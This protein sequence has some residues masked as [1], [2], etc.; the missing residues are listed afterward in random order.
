MFKIDPKEVDGFTL[1]KRHGA[2]SVLNIESKRKTH[3]TKL[4]E[5]TTKAAATTQEIPENQFS[6]LPNALGQEG[7]PLSPMASPVAT[8]RILRATNDG[9]SSDVDEVS[10][11]MAGILTSD[12]AIN[13]FARFGS[14]TPVKFV[15]LIQDPDAKVSRCP[16][17][18]LL[19]AP[20]I[21]SPHPI[22]VLFCF[23]LLL[24]LCAV[25]WPCLRAPRW[26]CAVPLSP[27]PLQ[28]RAAQRRPVMSP[29]LGTIYGALFGLISELCAKG[30]ASVSAA[31]D[32]C[33][34]HP[35]PLPY[36]AQQH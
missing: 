9:K 17:C 10:V 21:P 15:H 23:D 30:A 22:Y 25:I 2:V 7:R 27:H 36:P 26:R 3:S 11:I 31:D 19:S 33:P 28:A 13:F 18:P 29:A 8:T 35:V 6:F 5:T 4:R 16:A 24:P 1:P 32:H 20:A 34:F 14:E 12:D